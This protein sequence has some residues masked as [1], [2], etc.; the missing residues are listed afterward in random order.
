MP[1]FSHHTFLETITFDKKFFVTLLAF[2][3]VLF[4]DV[5]DGSV[6]VR[7][8]LKQYGTLDG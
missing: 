7:Y 6:N 4:L 2:G 3:V 8:T 5:D 1:T